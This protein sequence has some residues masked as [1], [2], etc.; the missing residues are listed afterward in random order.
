MPG[1]LHGAPSLG[2]IV[3]SVSPGNCALLSGE[4]L[5]RGPAAF[6]LGWLLGE[7]A[8]MRATNVRG[9]GGLPDDRSG[10]LARALLDG[11]GPPGDSVTT[12]R[13]ATV[14]VFTHAHDYAAFVGWH[15]HVTD[16]LDIIADLIDEDGSS[17]TKW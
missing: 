2:L 3:P 6:D 13:A 11:Y 10:P 5:A 9:I 4:D 1:L 8:E 12:G 15:D 17:A 16:Y 7:L 14:R